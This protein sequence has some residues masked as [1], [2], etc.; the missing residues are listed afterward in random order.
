MNQSIN[1]AFYYTKKN[2]KNKI[3]NVKE[4]TQKADSQGA[5]AAVTRGT[6]ILTSLMITVQC[7][8]LK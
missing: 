6:H 4:V 1:R 2:G 8:N 3:Q 7:G 5:G